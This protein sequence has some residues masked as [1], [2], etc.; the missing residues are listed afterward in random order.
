M[1]SGSA[2]A[3]EPRTARLQPNGTL[4]AMQEMHSTPMD[5]FTEDPDFGSD[6]SSEASEN[7]VVS[8]PR[9]DSPEVTIVWKDVQVVRAIVSRVHLFSRACLGHPN[10]TA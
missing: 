6:A 9:E 1:I 7:V 8:V 2:A 10:C 4:D 3:A 5:S